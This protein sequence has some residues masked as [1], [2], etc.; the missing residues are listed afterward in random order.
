MGPEQNDLKILSVPRCNSSIIISYL[1]PKSKTF[2]YSMTQT[3]HV[4]SRK[5]WQGI[6]TPCH[7]K[8]GDFDIVA[9]GPKH[10]D[11]WG[12][13]C[14]N[15][16]P[17]RITEDMEYVPQDS[18]AKKILVAYLKLEPNFIILPCLHRWSFWIYYFIHVE[19]WNKIILS[20]PIFVLLYSKLP[21]AQDKIMQ[22]VE[23]DINKIC[24]MFKATIQGNL[25]GFAPRPKSIFHVLG[26]KTKN[27]LF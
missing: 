24:K 12:L 8:V 27:I 4:R 5:W 2:G 7:D 22:S 18:K 10:E 9:W 23:H 26:L 19:I 21:R 17:N 20:F 25:M 15:P 6:M 1:G 16:P 11:T 14:G 13:G 3:R